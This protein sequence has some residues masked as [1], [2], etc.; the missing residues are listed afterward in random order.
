MTRS[1]SVDVVVRHFFLSLNIRRGRITGTP[2]IP[3]NGHNGAIEYN[4]NVAKNQQKILNIIFRNPILPPNIQSFKKSNSIPNIVKTIN[5]AN[6][7]TTS[8]NT[9]IPTS[10]KLEEINPSIIIPIHKTENII[11][12]IIKKIHAIRN[13]ITITLIMSSIKSNIIKSPPKN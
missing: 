13:I 11:P 2:M 1:S 3:Y 12:P 9:P 10:P 5:N 6:T 8:A 7:V 4:T